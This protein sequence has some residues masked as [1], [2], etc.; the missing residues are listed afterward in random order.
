LKSDS[1]SDNDTIESSNS[2][3]EENP[4]LQYVGDLAENSPLPVNIP[5]KIPNDTNP[6]NYP[7][8]IKISYKDN[9]RND[10]QLIV[11]GTVNYSP[12]IENSSN[13]TGLNL[14]F[15]NPIVL[16]G[17]FLVIIII[18]FLIFRRFRK[19]KKNKVDSSMDDTETYT[20]LDSVLNDNN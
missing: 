2:L 14:G 8:F 18:V 9:L 5:L 16:I 12:Q 1:G 15:I 17:L 20:D 4:P 10:H 11:N 6:G 19:K 13:D 7:I 3:V